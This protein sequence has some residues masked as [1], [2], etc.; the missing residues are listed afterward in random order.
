MKKPTAASG[1]GKQDRSLAAQGLQET[2][3]ETVEDRDPLANLKLLDENR[4]GF[5]WRGTQSLKTLVHGADAPTDK[6]NR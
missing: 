1:W 4:P 6:N 2:K 3:V 5:H